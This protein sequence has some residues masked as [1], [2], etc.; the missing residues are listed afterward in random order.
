M[1]TIAVIG[2]G[3][4]GEALISGLVASGVNPESITATNRTPQRREELARRY[5]V[6]TTDDNIEAVSGAD[7]T[8]LCVKP[9]A[10]LE[11]ISEI[12]ETIADHDGSSVVVS[13]AAGI[14]L[15]AM[16]GAAH[17]VGTALVR[18]MPNTP[19]QV[20]KGVS[21]V[22][23]GKYVEDD[24]REVVTELLG[25]TGRVAVVPEPLIDAASAISGSGPAY[26]FL[27]TEALIDAGVHMGLP[28]DTATLLATSTA[29]GAGVMLAHSGSSPADL[30]AGVCSP[31]GTTVQAI[32][33]LEESGIRGALYRA[34]SAA[35]TRAAE[36]GGDS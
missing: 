4:I 21:V 25:A 18:V 9:Y 29:E 30:R 16:A 27:V 5:G 33:E 19:M 17:N 34:T 13:M 2:A 11:L 23:F 3:N 8:F 14:T 1:S 20:G 12:S 15:E 6:I 10:V 28:R 7:V 24:Q 31:A 36:L 32:R 35:A 22:A 26:Y